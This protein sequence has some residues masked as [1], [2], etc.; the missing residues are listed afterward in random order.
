VIKARHLPLIVGVNFDPPKAAAFFGGDD[1]QKEKQDIEAAEANPAEL[2]R[3]GVAFA[4]GSGHA[5]DYLAG[6][7]KAIE[8]GL[9]SEIALRAAT[10]GAAEVLGVADRTGS[11][12]PGKLGNVVAWSGDPFAKETKARLV[13]VDGRLYEPDPSDKPEDK[14]DE[15]PTAAALALPR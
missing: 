3:A 5:K 12:E 4:L 10:L 11:L 15:T 2:H 6:V 13:F 8:K 7:R 14:K 9:P 1:E